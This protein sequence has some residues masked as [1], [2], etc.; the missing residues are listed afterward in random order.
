MRISEVLYHMYTRYKHSFSY[1]T[2]STTPSFDS[3]VYPV[4]SGFS[5]CANRRFLV[6][7][8][9]FHIRPK[10]LIEYLRVFCVIAAVLRMM[11]RMKGRIIKIF[12]PFRQ[13]EPTVCSTVTSKLEILPKRKTVKRSVGKTKMP[14]KKQ[15]LLQ[16]ISRTET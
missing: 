13:Q 16:N 6:F 10:E 8:R 4:Y 11:Q 9:H 12:T 7:L 14:Q 2:A 5:F 3:T 1:S 15:T